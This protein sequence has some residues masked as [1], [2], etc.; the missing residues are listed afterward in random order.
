MQHM[1]CIK[2]MCTMSHDNAR[3]YKFEAQGHLRDNS[4]CR[5]KGFFNSSLKTTPRY[6]SNVLYSLIVLYKHII[7]GPCIILPDESG[8]K[9]VT[10]SF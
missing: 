6:N 5:F 10:S 7:C 1:N 2:I 9:L 8:C 3:F 4:K